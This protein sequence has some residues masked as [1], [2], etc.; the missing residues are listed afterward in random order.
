MTRCGSKHLLSRIWS[1]LTGSPSMEPLL[2]ESGWSITLCNGPRVLLSGPEGE[3][4]ELLVRPVPPHDPE[5]QLVRA[6]RRGLI[7]EG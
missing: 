6:F 2:R 3:L 7:E 5:A 1:D 4:Y